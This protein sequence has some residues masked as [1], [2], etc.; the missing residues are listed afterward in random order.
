MGSSN[1]R[2]FIKKY[3]E[4][5]TL[6]IKNRLKGAGKVASGKL[7]RSIKF[8]IRDS[9]KELEA[10]WSMEDYGIFVDK[11]VQGAI[12]GKAGDGGKSEYKFGFGSKSK[13]KEKSLKKW[14]KIKGIPKEKYYVISRN[15]W[16][17][18]ITPT[19]F[20]TIP[21]TRRQKQFEKGLGEAI[22]KDID[23]DLQ[24]ELK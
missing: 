16:A 12:S 20:F 6:E 21:T 24:K 23:N 9:V 13:E 7:Y 2:D 14:M 3:G 17:F 4:S 18:G 5:V 11:G 10:S 8:N 22:A 1:T 15:I 19:N